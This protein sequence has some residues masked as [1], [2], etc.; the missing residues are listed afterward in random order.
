[1]SVPRPGPLRFLLAAAIGGLSMSGCTFWNAPRFEASVAVGDLP[2]RWTSG[3]GVPAEAVTGWLDDFGSRPL[4]SLVEEA[5][6]QNYDLAAARARID[7]ARTRARLAGADRLPAIDSAVS[8]SRSQNLRGSDFRNTRA[9][10]FNFS[11]DLSWE[12]DLWGRL[13]NLRDAE[14][15]RVAIETELY[16]ASRLSLAGNV[17]KTA[18]AIVEAKGQ[19]EISR[20]TLASYRTNLEILDSRMEA[21]DL[22]D[23]AALEISLSRADIARAERAILLSQRQLDGS[24][25]DLEVLLGRY[26]AGAVESL[27]ALPRISR[28]V[29]KGLPSELLLR[30]PDLLAA[31][32]RVDAS[33]KELAAS[34]KAL[35]PALSL[36]GALGTAS[37]DEFGD[38]FDIQNMVWS[39]GQNLARPLYQG[40]RLRAN[41]R[42]DEAER[43]ELVRTYAETALTAF[44]EVERGLAAERFLKAEVAALA[45]AAQESRRAERLSLSE[46]QE[47]LVEIITLLESQRRAFDAESSLLAA[48]LELLTNRV[49]LYLALGGDFDHLP[50]VAARPEA[51]VRAKR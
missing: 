16:E 23:R 41:I 34:R 36:N 26:P 15:D 49:D 32:A 46:Y 30:R 17:V 25:R 3:G 38:L 1:M 4:R 45:T 9:N 12:I 2:S 48:R 13:K 8:T 19:I 31:E 11:L 28:E 27:S 18:L 40:G 14:L 47:G 42:L 50:P 33:L 29:P 39:V 35:L 7:Q 20:R 24:R 10:N 51:A 21:G 37:T 44:N 22:A 43:D 6:G 5:V